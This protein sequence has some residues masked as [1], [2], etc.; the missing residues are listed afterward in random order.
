[1]PGL[2]T[3]ITRPEPSSVPIRR[4]LP[5]VWG[6]RPP[7]CPW[8]PQKC[9]PPGRVRTVYEWSAGTEMPSLSLRSGS[10]P[11][12][13]TACFLPTF[14]TP[15]SPFV[16]TQQWVCA[17]GGDLYTRALRKTSFVFPTQN[18]QNTSMHTESGRIRKH[19]CS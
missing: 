6:S 16:W 8:Q 10:F 9:S 4:M 18:G 5:I 17:R 13:Q 3:L 11:S 12:G 2:L 7:L 1:M 19:I 14:K 15:N